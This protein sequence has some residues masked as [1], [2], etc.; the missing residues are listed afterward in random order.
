MTGSIAVYLANQLL[1]DQSKVYQT[2]QL[3]FAFVPAYHVS[4]KQIGGYIVYWWIHNS[5][6][7]PL[8]DSRN[9]YTNRFLI[10]H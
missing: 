10:S 4:Y 2:N 6:L 9:F 7:S 3:C 1:S 8:P 5:P